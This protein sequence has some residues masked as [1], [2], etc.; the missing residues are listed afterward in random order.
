MKIT[1]ILLTHNNERFIENCLKSVSFCDEILILDKKSND[2]TL[3]IAQKYNS[4]IIKFDG[5]HFDEWRNL[6]IKNAKNDWIFY[7]DPDERVTPE[8]KKEILN[9]VKSPIKRGGLNEA[10]SGLY[11]AY[12]FPR[13]N[14]WWGKEF[15]HCGSWPD[16]VTRLFFKSKLEKWQGIIHESPVFKGELGTLNSPLIHLTHTDLTTGLKKSISWTSMEA[17]LFVK[18]NHPKVKWYNI[19]KVTISEFLRKYLVQKGY[20]E[21]IEGFLESM[22]QAF[23]R[24]LVYVQIWELQQKPSI[25]DKYKELD[26]NP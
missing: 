4:K 1:V 3:Q 12:R 20:K 2:Q 23:N 25:E 5:E 18:G 21:G 13:K 14:Y 8:L 22:V 6:G 15:K 9:I 19:A 16:Y 24:F 11:S 7:I 26:K 17:E 10:K